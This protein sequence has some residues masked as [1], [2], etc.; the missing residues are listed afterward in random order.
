MGR[1]YRDAIVSGALG[2]QRHAARTSTTREGAGW[3]RVLREFQGIRGLRRL[4]LLVRTEGEDLF[5]AILRP[6]PV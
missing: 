5:A 4:F 2:G 3:V 6:I 1:C